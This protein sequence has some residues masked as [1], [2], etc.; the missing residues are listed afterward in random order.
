M[1]VHYNSNNNTKIPLNQSNSKIMKL[2]LQL[3]IIF[4]F[5]ITVSAVLI[6][7]SK[8]NTESASNLKSKLN[9][10][11]IDSEEIPNLESNQLCHD[12]SGRL[13]YV[14]HPTAK[15]IDGSRPAYY[16]RNGYGNGNGK[17]MIHFEGGGWCFDYEV[18]ISII[19][20][21][22]ETTLAM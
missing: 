21:I 17:W 19:I 9:G 14:N 15:C 22:S 8:K 20:L 4:V 18:H 6:N 10:S 7:F 1:R 13:F 3:C 5:G 11:I 12:K 16:L 2:I